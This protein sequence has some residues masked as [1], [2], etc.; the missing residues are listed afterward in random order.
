M[1]CSTVKIKSPSF[2]NSLLVNAF[3]ISFACISNH[4]TE[5]WLPKLWKLFETRHTGSAVHSFQG[6][7]CLVLWSP[8]WSFLI[9][10]VLGIVCPAPSTEAFCTAHTIES[11][12]LTLYCAPTFIFLSL[13]ACFKGLHHPVVSRERRGEKIKPWRHHLSAECQ[14][15]SSPWWIVC[16]GGTCKLETVFKNKGENIPPMS[17]VLTWVCIWFLFYSVTLFYSLWNLYSFLIAF[18][19]MLLKSQGPHTFDK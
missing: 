14:I 6:F 8:C 19:L 2:G 17:S 1:Q 4:L 13:F 11:L 9:Y 7:C 16:L 3:I 5:L 12:G 15:P 10:S 18:K